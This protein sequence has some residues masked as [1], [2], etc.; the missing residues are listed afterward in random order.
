M[1]YLEADTQEWLVHE[2]EKLVVGEM[3]PAV[4]EELQQQW[5]VPE[6]SQRVQERFVYEFDVEEKVVSQH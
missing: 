6:V 3:C 4:L 5:E 2:Q 1:G